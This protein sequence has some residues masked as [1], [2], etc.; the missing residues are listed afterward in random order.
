ML[1]ENGARWL[2]EYLADPTNETKR[3]RYRHDD[4]RAALR[5]ET[6]WKCVFCESRIGHNTPGDVEHKKPASKFQE[7]RFVWD[8]LTVACTECNRRKSDYHSDE[9]PFIDP[10]LH[11]VEEDVVH[12]GPLV[13]WRIGAASAEFSVRKLELHL[14][15]RPALI[16]QKLDVLARA[17]ALIDLSAN[18]ADPLT[19]VR[20][21]EL[22]KMQE[23]NAEFSACVR[24]FVAV[25][26][27]SAALWTA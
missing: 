25:L 20:L 10:Y 18:D 11:A 27:P 24:A 3:K 12:C 19:P 15:D 13:T 2:Q 14:Y 1:V 23:K 17:R 5:E 9:L 16:Q 22:R 8:N 4:V 6:G 21:D 26:L 7:L